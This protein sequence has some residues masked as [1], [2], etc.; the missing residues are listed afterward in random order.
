M[1]I[2]EQSFYIIVMFLLSIKVG[3]NYKTDGYVVT[4]KTMELLQ[5]HVEEVGGKVFIA[6]LF[7][8]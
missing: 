2:A 8:V 6:L 5:K 4:P 7:S 1:H 3:E